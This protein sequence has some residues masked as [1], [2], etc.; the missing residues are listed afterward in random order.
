MNRKRNFFTFIPLAIAFIP[1]LLAIALPAS[2]VRAQTITV[3]TTDDEANADGDCSLRE[4][5][6]AANGDVA[7]DACDAGA[8]ADIIVVP[9]GDYTLTLAGAGEEEALSGDLDLTSEL[10]ID[11]AGMGLT[12]IDGA[13]ADR[14]FDIHSGARVVI[15][16][17]TIRNGAADN[18]A[19]I[20]AIGPLTLRN[21]RVTGNTASGV[22]GGL[23]A[24]NAITVT[25]SRLDGNQAASGGGLFVSFL[26]VIVMRS[27]ISGNTVDGGGGG[28]YSSGALA[29][30]NSTLSGNTAGGSGG[31]LLVVENPSNYLYNV[32]ISDN[33]A[34]A[35]NQFGDG[36]GVLAAGG[37]HAANSLISGN[38]DLGATD[39]HPDCSG[40]LQS[41][42]YN[43]LGNVAGCTISGDT[44]GN[45][46]GVDALL[47]PLQNNGGATFTHALLPGSPALDA[48]NP[49]GCDDHDGAPLTTDQRGASRPGPGSARCDIGAYEAGDAPPPTATPT[50][51]PHVTPTPTA[52]PP[53]DERQF[54]PAIYR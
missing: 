11:G 7:V 42:G 33:T 30:A 1:L 37:L 3:N 26:E 17:V 15:R 5:I 44:T 38:H 45:L 16:G 28:V 53:G 32:T 39:V 48:G 24:G 40:N 23:Y 8:G 9:A 41:E 14:I 22:G 29:I 19:G 6:L 46:L 13:A 4:A 49:G 54:L 51:D 35:A 50:V 12:N 25:E 36:G 47:D 27:E 43:L 21:S 20:L 18:G 34:G 52:T 31:G 10:T 2:P